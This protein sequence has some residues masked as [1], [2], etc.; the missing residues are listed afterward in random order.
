MKR[1]T[2]G[3]S[4]SCRL[5]PLLLALLMSPAGA[6]AQ[7]TSDANNLY[8]AEIVII[9]RLA[10]DSAAQEQ[11]A[12]RTTAT[13]TRADQ[14]NARR[15]WVT[16]RSGNRA[17]DLSLVDRNNLYLASAAR[18]LENSG[19]YR[20][21][22]T[23]AWYESFPPD[24]D[25]DPLRVETGDWL[26]GADQRAVQGH[27]QIERKRYLHV[28]AHLNHWRDGTAGGAQSDMESPERS[29]TP[30][31]ASAQDATTG[32][33]DPAADEQPG[34]EMTVSTGDDARAELVTWIRE[35]RRMRSEEI[36]FIDSPTIGVLVFFKKI[37]E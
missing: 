15:L 19:R 2:L 34:P 32:Q 8:R 13:E 21:L 27:I 4:A 14:D 9:E 23:A 18:R 37:E 11:M 10:A 22:A 12:S 17:S 24:Y 20:V 7:D 29:E 33:A 6:L 28:N 26:S 16:D 36:H 3:P 30:Q 31:E 5:L 35:T 25:G 1:F